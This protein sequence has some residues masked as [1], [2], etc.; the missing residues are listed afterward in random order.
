[1][2]ITILLSFF[3]LTACF[4]SKSLPHSGDTIVSH[5]YFVRHA[6][7]DTSNPSEKNPHL[8][9]KG[10]ERA[11]KWSDILSNEKFDFVYSTDYYRTRETAKPIAIRNTTKISIY[12]PNHIDYES[13]FKETN[14]KNVFIVGHSNTIPAFIN[15]IIGTK[16]YEDIDHDNNGNL[17]IVTRIDDKTSSQ[18]LTFN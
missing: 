6:E 9:T 10:Q 16:K 2:K 12:D 18:L 1:M 11:E 4:Q 7:K 15:S 13:F 14:G 3:I 5:Y 8:T 17:Y